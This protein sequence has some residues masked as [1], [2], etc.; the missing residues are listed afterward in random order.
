M[1]IPKP[2]VLVH[3]GEFF[4]AG[5]FELPD[6]SPMIRWSRAV[7]RRFERRALG[8]YAGSLLYPGNE[9]TVKG[10]RENCIVQPSYSFTW[11]FDEAALDAAVR[12]NCF[13]DFISTLECLRQ[14][15]RD[16]ED[17]LVVWRSPHTVGGHGYTHSIPNYGRVLREGLGEHACRIRAGLTAA[18][19]RGAGCQIDFYEG[20]EDVLEGIRCWHRRIVEHLNAW[21]PGNEAGARNRDRL[22]EALRRVPFQPACTFYEAIVAYNFVYYLDDCDNPGRL[23][24]ELSPYYQRDI[25]RGRTA[26][27]DALDL[28]GEFTDNVCANGGWSAAIGGT[29]P[30]G[31]PAYNDLTVLCLEAVR[32]KYRPSYE[33][34]VRPDMPDAVWEAALETIGTG[35]GQP[36][37]YNER[38]Y[39]EGLRRAGLGIDDKDLVMWNGGGCT[40]TMIHGCSNVGS[41]DAGINLLLILQDTLKSCLAEAIDF[42]A[43][44]EDYKRDVAAV[45]RDIADGVSRLQQA[46]AALRPQPMR[47]LLMDDCIDRGLE[48]NVG[49]A[50]YNWSVV[51]VAGL[52]NVADSLA[53]VREVVFGKEIT[54]AALLDVLERDFEGA[55]A[56]RQRLAGC[57]RFGNDRPEVDQIATQVARFCF[58]EFRRYAP[59]RG[60]RFLPSCIMFTTYTEAGEAVGAT[61]DGRRAGTPVADSIGPVAGRDRRGPTAMLESV[62]RLPL[63][64]AIGTPVLNVRFSGDLFRSVEGRQAIRDLIRTYFDLGGLQIQISVVDQA[65]LRDAIAH[66]ERHEDL[67]VRIGGFSAHFNSLSPD[68]KWTVLERT[69]HIV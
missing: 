39:L 6:A 42:E 38:A 16:L 41:L 55:E 62:T 40:E 53:A 10:V 3:L 24:R 56:L 19:E 27:Q 32:H 37:L 54:G 52:S 36:A 67:I 59:W 65:V 18:R 68:L 31:A 51:N 9:R 22:V 61:P 8:S 49:G 66:P 44:V 64:L 17:S 14:E 69:E 21:V 35:C 25:E 20:L 11:A 23:D 29:L 47:S 7:R 28:L 58:E 43:L 33:L 50:R 46:K 30:G 15:M 60:G 57:P 12:S 13:S 2:D 63:E 1:V 5:Y 48:F 45:V 34:A 26:R 4:A